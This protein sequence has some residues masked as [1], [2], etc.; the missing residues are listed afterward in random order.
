MLAIGPSRLRRRLGRGA[1]LRRAE[2]LQPG[3]LRPQGQHLPQVPDH[4]DQQHAEDQPVQQRV[5]AEGPRQLRRQQHRDRARPR[6]G[7]RPCAR[8]SRAAGSS[9]CP[10]RL[11]RRII[12]HVIAPPPAGAAARPP[13]PRHRRSGPAAAGRSGSAPARRATSACFTARLR[14]RLSRRATRDIGRRPRG[15]AG[16]HDPPVRPG[17]EAPS[18]LGQGT[19][20]GRRQALAPRRRSAG[21][22]RPAAGPPCPRAGPAAA[23]TGPRAAPAPGEAWRTGRAGPAVPGP[24]RRAAGRSPRRRRPRHPAARVRRPRR[25][26][27]G[28]GAAAAGHRRT[29]GSPPGAGWASGAACPA[30]SAAPSSQAEEVCVRGH[31]RQTRPA[32]RA[33]SMA[34]A[35]VSRAVARSA[36]LA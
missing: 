14:A 23:G 1:Q 36:R 15:L 33:A 28:C 19:G 25:A 6:P 24:G 26:A 32:R 10:H 16:E 17:G 35:P 4:A 8:G 31:A 7:S 27:R 20:G 21:G 11:G 12:G 29:A 5:G 2:M 3:D 34:A 13:H 22:S 9:S 30:A 18:Q